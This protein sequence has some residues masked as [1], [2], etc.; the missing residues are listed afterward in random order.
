MVKLALYTIL[1]DI[2]FGAVW[3]VQHFQA[4]IKLRKVQG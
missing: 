1:F 3:R 4:Y 2:Y